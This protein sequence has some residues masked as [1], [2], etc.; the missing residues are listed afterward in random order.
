MTEVLIAEDSPLLREGLAAG[1]SQEGMSVVA[2]VDN[3][4][5]LRAAI[6]T[7]SPDVALVGVP[8]P[9]VGEDE[10]LAA[11]EAIRLGHP[12]VGVL[13]LSGYFDP[14]LAVGLISRRPASTG[15]LLKE[16]VPDM[17]TLV[18]ALRVVAAGGTFVDRAVIERLRSARSRP[19]LET[20]SAREREILALMAEGRTNCAICD[21]LQLSPKTVESH[22]RAVFGKLD[23]RAAPDDHRRVLAVLRYLR[24]KP[25][26]EAGQL[27]GAAR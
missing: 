4:V 2:K 5:A 21:A 25:Q 7:A 16:P 22:V 26:H 24:A 13:A 14:A 19:A 20:L 9:P 1:L 12:G 27:V 8:M 3:A 23:L 18:R 15:Y 11:I 17:A 10:G 6:A